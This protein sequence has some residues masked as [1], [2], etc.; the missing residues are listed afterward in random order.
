MDFIISYCQQDTS[1]GLFICGGLVNIRFREDGEVFRNT[2]QINLQIQEILNPSRLYFKIY[3]SLDDLRAIA[4]ASKHVPANTTN[5]YV[6]E[7]YFTISFSNGFE[8]Q[9]FG[10]NCITEV[11]K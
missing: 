11:S 1:N 8:S 7:G 3:Q 2:E 6:K 9:F 5:A 4:Y 10:N